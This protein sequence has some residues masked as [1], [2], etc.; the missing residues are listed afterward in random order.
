MIQLTLSLMAR[1][2][3][4]CRIYPIKNFLINLFIF[5]YK[6]NMQEAMHE[7]AKDYSSFNDFF[8]RRLKPNTR[9]L[10]VAPLISPAD[11][12]LDSFGI[13]RQA[14]ILGA[15]PDYAIG[16]RAQDLAQE[17]N[18]T[19]ITAKRETPIIHNIKGIGY[20]IGDLLGLKDNNQYVKSFAEGQ[21]SVIY[22]APH[23]YHRVH[24]PCSTELLFANFIPGTLYSVNPKSVRRH[25][26]LYAHNQRMA[27]VFK[28]EYGL[29]GYIMVAALIVS[30]IGTAW[31]Q[32]HRATAKAQIYERQQVFAKGDE[33][34]YFELGST[35]ILL[36]GKS[37]LLIDSCLKPGTKLKMGQAL[38][39]QTSS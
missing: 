29:I 18:A 6:P 14:R 25:P 10:S 7:K 27:C 21:Y 3:T 1:Y 26:S 22:L 13:I 5:I 19:Q 12:T 32:K 31:G 8:I 4:D 35:V 11:G 28:T 37:Q 38:Y 17:A 33:L 9:P 34:G 16:N 39:R 36:L 15:K 2:L 30:S 20:S 24:T 23:N